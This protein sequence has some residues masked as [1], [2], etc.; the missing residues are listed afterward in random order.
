MEMEVSGLTG[1]AVALIA[2]R[3]W[4]TTV[5]SPRAKYIYLVAL[6]LLYYRALRLYL[7]TPEFSNY[8]ASNHERGTEGRLI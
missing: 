5:M 7:Q 3:L 6:T 8:K 4:C 2:T 1:T